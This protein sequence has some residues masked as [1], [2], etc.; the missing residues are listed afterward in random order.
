MA[1]FS[2]LAHAE[3]ERGPEVRQAGV[4]SLAQCGF[5][6]YSVR[7]SQFAAY[8]HCGETTV[9]LHATSEGVAARMTTT[10]ASAPAPPNYRAQVRTISTRTTSAAPAA[11]AEIATDTHP[12]EP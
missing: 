10:S 6:R 4:S 1:A 3:S 2:G 5:F 11:G 8:N 9:R 7:Q 12:I